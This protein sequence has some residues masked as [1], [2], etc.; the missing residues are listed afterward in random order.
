MANIEQY[1]KINEGQDV[2]PGEGPVGGANLSPQATLES[3]KRME[4]IKIPTEA[5][6]KPGMS[7]ENGS[8]ANEIEVQKYS[9]DEYSSMSL[10]TKM[11]RLNDPKFIEWINSNLKP[12]EFN[13]L[14]DS[15]DVTSQKKLAEGIGLLGEHCETSLYK[16]F[17]TKLQGIT[18]FDSKEIQDYMVHHKDQ[19]LQIL[20][21]TK[22]TLNSGDADLNSKMKN[23]VLVF[24]EMYQS[25]DKFPKVDM[26]NQTEFAKNKN[27]VRKNMLSIID[28]YHD[29]LGNNTDFIIWSPLTKWYGVVDQATYDSGI[30]FGSSGFND[31]LTGGYE[32][33]G[34]L[35]GK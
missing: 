4:E 7:L 15:L 13:K 30:S 33:P 1:K 26:T 6:L 27:I 32:S 14:Y 24:Y 22:M 8:V 3:L 35:A 17:M 29:Y 28:G 25:S 31:G 23:L 20:G 34:S 21:E 19:F 5:G 11:D 18:G 16:N 10:I 12:E 9:M 2:L